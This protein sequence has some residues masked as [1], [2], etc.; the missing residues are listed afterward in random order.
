MGQRTDPRR[1]RRGRATTGRAGGALE[2]P[3]VARRW[4]DQVVAHVLVAE[5]GRVRLAEEDCASRAQAAGDAAVEVGDKVLEEFG[6]V[7]GAQ[8]SRRL[9]VFHRDGQTVQWPEWIA[10]HDRRF[11]CPRRI[12]RAL[13][14]E[15]HE[16]VHGRL[17]T[18]GSVEHIVQDFDW[19]Q[20]AGADGFGQAGGRS[21]SERVG[22]AR[23]VEAWAGSPWLNCTRKS[24]WPWWTL[25]TVPGSPA[26]SSRTRAAARPIRD[27]FMRRSRFWLFRLPTGPGRPAA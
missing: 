4:P 25:S 5:V 2:V 20:T 6:A 18:L 21:V 26:T 8:S 15:G 7:R 3:G 17:Q 9:E 14:V 23:S 1:D 10:A 22:H 16:R 24:G 13:G 19:R 11:G 27:N 12:S